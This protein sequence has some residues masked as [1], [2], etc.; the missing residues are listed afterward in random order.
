MCLRKISVVQILGISAHLIGPCPAT[1]LPIKS[2]RQTL[3]AEA[4]PGTRTLDMRRYLEANRQKAVYLKE[5]SEQSRQ[6][7]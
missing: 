4:E 5:R 2:F 6:K 1:S 3:V 7:C